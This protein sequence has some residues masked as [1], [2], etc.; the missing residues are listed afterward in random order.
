MCHSVHVHMANRTNA[1]NYILT[2]HGNVDSKL[3]KLNSDIAIYKTLKYQ[4][5]D[6]QRSLS[7]NKIADAITS[8]APDPEP[9]DEQENIPSSADRTERV[10]VGQPSTSGIL[11]STPKKR[12]SRTPRGYNDNLRIGDFND[13]RGLETV[14][15][16]DDVEENE[17][18]QN[19]QTLNEFLDNFNSQQPVDEL[20]TVNN[21]DNQERVDAA[22]TVS[23]FYSKQYI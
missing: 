10:V 13:T 5:E 20:S 11:T 6:A 23:M 22:P 15:F 9:T 8:P 7:S 18:R 16:A 1:S 19:N 14:T 2:L 12:V 3:I 4:V 21:A 17:R